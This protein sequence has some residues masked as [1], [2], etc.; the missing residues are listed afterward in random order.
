MILVQEGRIFICFLI[1]V[2]PQQFGLPCRAPGGLVASEGEKNTGASAKQGPTSGQSSIGPV[3]TQFFHLPLTTVPVS[4]APTMS[5]LEAF[6][7][8]GKGILPYY[9]LIVSRQRLPIR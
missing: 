3:V 2:V 7:P 4:T 8:P 1:P 6:L 9:M 5:G